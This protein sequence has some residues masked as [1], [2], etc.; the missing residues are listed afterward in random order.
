MNKGYSGIKNELI[1]VRKSR[2][3][4]KRK[5]HQLNNLYA[6]LKIQ[7]N[8]LLGDNLALKIMLNKKEKTK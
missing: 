8:K 3:D 2:D 5:Y 6:E 7:R 4:W 1:K